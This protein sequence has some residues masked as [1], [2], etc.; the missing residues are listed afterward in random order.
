M[1]IRPA[2]EEDI[3]GIAQVI[4]D[5]WKKAY[6]DIVAD[7]FLDALSYKKQQE[8][9]RRYMFQ[10]DAVNFVAED[11][12]GEIVGVVSGGRE[13]GGDAQYPGEMYVIYI[14]AEHH[15]RGLGRGLTASWAGALRLRGI[16]S[17]LVWVLAENRPAIEF[18]QRLGAH[19]VREQMLQLGKQSLRE[20]ALAWD[21]LGAVAAG[22]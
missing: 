3:P 18:Y 1:N 21:D 19:P 8:R 9:S 11:P 12:N 15:R 16:N 20:I 2:L 13:R 6:R 14:L 22:K 5:T 4:T 7:S 10:A 17:A